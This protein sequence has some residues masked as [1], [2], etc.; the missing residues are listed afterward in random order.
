M[1][2]VDRI[3]TRA[4]ELYP[5]GGEGAPLPISGGG[6]VPASPEGAGGL[7]VGVR[8][9]AGSYQQA[10]TAAAGLDQELQQAAEQGGVIGAQGRQASGVIRDQARAVAA[11]TEALGR[12][13]AGAHLIMAA[14]NQHL[15]AMQT[16]L[17]TTKT[18]YQAVS[19]TLRQTAAGYQT[20]SGDDKES[21]PA[22]PLDSSNKWKPGD[23]RHKPY[24]AGVGGMGP[25]NYPGSPPWVDIYDRTKDPDQ[26]PHYFVRS[27]EIPGYKTLPPGALGPPTVA[28]EHGNPDPYIEL[29]PN[30]GVWVP[31]SAFP[32]AK[33][34]PPGGG[35]LPPYGWDEYLPG[36]GIFVW[37][38][39]LVPEPYKPYGPLGPPT[40]PQGGR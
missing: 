16:Q 31:Q 18:Q 27:D 14:M 11:S 40:Y 24:D 23:K 19:A 36:S 35:G 12:T 32:G 15:S 20:L 17:Q 37:H 26:V 10:R 28:D 30:S 33:I 21:P 29:S 39:D 4:H 8:R 7:H 3:L 6:S 34:Y 5:A 38:G 1:A 2:G 25:P 9:A 13:P 22:V